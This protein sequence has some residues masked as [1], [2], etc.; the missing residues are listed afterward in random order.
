MLLDGNHIQKVH[1]IKLEHKL[2]RQFLRF[3][4]IK[5]LILSFYFTPDF[6]AGSFRAQAL[7]DSINRNKKIKKVILLSTLP[8]RYGHIK[9]VPK[10]EKLGKAEVYRFYTPEHNNNF[11]KQII[12]FLFFPY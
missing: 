11:I 10:Y 8:Q 5:F 1:F 12:A 2:K 4:T 6:C 3:S 9:G 7:I